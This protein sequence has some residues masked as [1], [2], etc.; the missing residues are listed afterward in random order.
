M[1][2]Q[3]NAVIPHIIDQHAEEA[4]F[5]WLLRNNAINA[6]HYDLNDLAKLDDRI[7]AHLDGL[8]I[9]ADYGW[10]VCNENLQ[11]KES[12]EVFVA[13]ILALEGNSIERINQVYKIVEQAPE[14]ING[15]VSAF[16][17]VKPH[18][19]QGKV[20]GLLISEDPLWRMAG[21]AA[22]AIHRVDPGKFLE[23]A[24]QD[25][26]VSLRVRGLKAVGELGRVDLK[27]FLLEQL[28][29]ENNK[30]RFWA[31][32]SA[33]LIGDR[34]LALSLLCKEIES[35][36]EFCIKAMQVA[37]P[38]LDAQSIKQTLKALADN[39]DTLRQAVIGAGIS[40]DPC[41]IS[42]LIQQMN[43]PQL[44][45]VAGESL[46]IICG[47]DL[48]D[49]DMEGDLPDGQMGGPSENPEDDD[50]AM[51]PDEDLLYP[52]PLLVQGWWQGNMHL[53]KPDVRYLYGKFSDTTQCEWLLRN[54]TQKLRY[55]A[56]LELALKRPEQAIYEIRAVGKRQQKELNC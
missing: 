40:G 39:Q 33:V 20:N 48:A 38:V 41:Y 27:T 35:N 15:L 34:S 16:G 37:L 36:S 19:L 12:G 18:N 52:D 49:Q 23:Q 10:T 32:W 54:G 44:A 31:A 24:I 53:F 4:A 29:H 50:V 56:A 25:D 22:C 5:L 14:T 45:R 8:R 42:W 46:S 51:D 1:T 55:I 9:S 30:V 11:L 6:P 3:T 28:N 17:W 47:V 43:D 21:I 7:D 26:D 13:A 2:N